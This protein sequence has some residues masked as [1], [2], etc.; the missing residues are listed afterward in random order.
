MWMLNNTSM[1]CATGAAALSA[2]CLEGAVNYAN[3]RTQFGQPIGKFQ[4]IQQQI[5][6]MKL[7]DEAAKFAVYKAAWLKGKQNAKP[8]GH[9]HGKTV[10][11][12]TQRCMAPTW[13]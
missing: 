2:A 11:G 10:Q 4:M 9:I 13:Q 1:G 5:A 3:E 6:E 12:A 8:A 7:E